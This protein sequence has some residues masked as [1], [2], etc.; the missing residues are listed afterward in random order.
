MENVTIKR[1]THAR[2]RHYMKRPVQE[3]YFIAEGGTMPP[4]PLPS[5]I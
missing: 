5:F 4:V 3:V 1:H 2:R